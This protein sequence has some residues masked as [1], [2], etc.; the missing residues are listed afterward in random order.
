MEPWLGIIT[1]KAIGCGSFHNVGERTCTINAFVEHDNAR[2]RPFL[3]VATAESILAK[4]QRL[5]KYI[6]GTIRQGM[7]A[8]RPGAANPGA[9]KPPR[10]HGR[11]SPATALVLW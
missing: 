6:S 5:C 1:Q 8:G 11:S 10:L 2:A 3:W 7:A 4:I 9:S